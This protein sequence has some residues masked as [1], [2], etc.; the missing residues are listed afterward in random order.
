MMYVSFVCLLCVCLLCKCN[1]FVC[2]FLIW[3]YA[4][5]LRPCCVPPQGPVMVVVG[6]ML[7]IAP[8]LLVPRLGLRNAMVA[9]LGM[10]AKEKPAAFELWAG[11]WKPYRTVASLHL[12]K[13][14]DNQPK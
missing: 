10:G 2:V 3:L 13:S 12:W 5:A 1:S 11:R 6:L 8:R 4:C 14:L 9:H 7:A